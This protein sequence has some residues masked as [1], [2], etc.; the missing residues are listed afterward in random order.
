MYKMLIGYRSGDM[1]APQL[2]PSEGLQNEVRHFSQCIQ[3]GERPVTDGHAGLRVV[4]ILEAATRSMKQRGRL[5]EL[6]TSKE[7]ESKLSMAAV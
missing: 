4:S 2:D 5:V 6:K 3:K 1:C 7:P